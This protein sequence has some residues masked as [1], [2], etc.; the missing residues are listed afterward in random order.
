MDYVTIIITA[1]ALAQLNLNQGCAFT[2]QYARL[3]ATMFRANLK[4]YLDIKGLGVQTLNIFGE[5]GKDRFIG[6]RLRFF[7]MLL[8]GLSPEHLAK[9][10]K[11]YKITKGA[12]ASFH[13]EVSNS[14]PS[15][16][17]SRTASSQA[18]RDDREFQKKVQKTLMRVYH[19]TMEYAWPSPILS[20]ERAKPECLISD[21]DEDNAPTAEELW[22]G[23]SREL[24]PDYVDTETTEAAPRKSGRLAKGKKAAV[25]VGHPLHMP[26]ALGLERQGD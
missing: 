16:T 15:H 24:L 14:H 18:D 21:D 19:A 4:A 1:V 22:D 13:I 6:A 23:A 3:G 26:G 11:V 10:R 25:A 8:L 9:Y 12:W 2:E 5:D 7:E 17:S 20:A